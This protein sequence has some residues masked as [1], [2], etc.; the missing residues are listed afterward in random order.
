MKRLILMCALAGFAAS[1]FAQKANVKKVRSK[2]EF[3]TTPINFDLSNLEA[4]KVQEI[5]E[6][7]EPALTD[8]E[9][10]D[11]V[12]TWKY[13]CR[14][15]IYDM[16]QLL[17]KYQA[18]GNKFEDPTAFFNNQYDVVKTF[19]RYEELMN[20]PN[21][22]GKL[23]YKEEE[24]KKEHTIAQTAAKGARENLLIGA[25]NVVYTDPATALKLL[26]L[27]YGTLDHSLYKELDL[28]TSDKNLSLGY[29][30]YAVALKATNGDEAKYVEYLVKSLDTAQGPSACQDLITFYKGKADKENETK[31]LKY[32]YEHFPNQIVFAVNLIQEAVSAHKYDEAIEMCDKTIAN[33]ESGVLPSTNEQG[34][35][36]DANKWP[37]YFKAVSLYSSEKLELAFDAFNA[38]LAIDDN[39]D[40]LSGAANCA[41]QLGMKT[42]D[43]KDVSKIWYN[44]AIELYEKC[45]A[46]YPDKEDVWGYQLYVCYN[47]T[48]N[49][50][51][52]KEFQKYSK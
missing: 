4:E 44:R 13:A 20:T 18:N 46:N 1:A 28:A 21:E 43:K 9:S 48:G 19:T 35:K 14:L 40:N 41:A 49:A 37:Y 52:A 30:I 25:S 5:R 32:G 36:I 10:K 6:L 8:P 26:D 31:Y 33:L 29:Y 50:A 16:N 45:R 51:K 23:P 7:I 17:A 12:D 34:A 39:F 15:K 22:K 47:N 38:A 3:S 42:A 11:M 27:Y 24:L 2:I